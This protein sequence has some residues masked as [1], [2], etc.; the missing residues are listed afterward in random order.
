MAF[1]TYYS[2]FVLSWFAAT[3][4]GLFVSVVVPAGPAA[5][6]TVMITFSMT[7]VSGTFPPLTFWESMGP[8]FSWI[9]NVS[10]L[11]WGIEVLYSGGKHLPYLDMLGLNQLAM[12]YWFELIAF[13]RIG[14]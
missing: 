12:M 9:P 5:I 11:R 6:A 1:L 4:V 10:F 7:I 3:G 14:C 8:P 2:V 13:V